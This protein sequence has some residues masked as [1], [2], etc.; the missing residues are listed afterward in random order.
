MIIRT[1]A[2]AR[3]ALIGNPSDGY[4]GKTISFTFKNFCAEVTLYETP[5]LEIL[6]TERDSSCFASI[7]DLAED[8]RLFGYYGGIR[9]L[10]AVIK[11]F[12]D[13]THAHGIKHDNR[14][15]TIRYESNIPILV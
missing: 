8:V 12:H 1:R 15:F 9:L 4:F 3:A 10:K 11:T 7:D 6:P 5:E 14:N 13:Y 2:Y